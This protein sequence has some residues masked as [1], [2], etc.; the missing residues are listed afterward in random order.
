MHQYPLQLGFHQRLNGLSSRVKLFS[1]FKPC[2]PNWHGPPQK[3]F[4]KILKSYSPRQWQLP[5]QFVAPSNPAANSLQT[6]PQLPILWI[7]CGNRLKLISVYARDFK[8]LLF[9]F[10]LKLIMPNEQ[11]LQSKPKKKQCPLIKS[12]NCQQYHLK[13]ESECA[14]MQFYTKVAIKLQKLAAT[15][16]RP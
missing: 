11:Y 16:P 10:P 4:P 12:C 15:M 14:S 9:V 1:L 2:C 7:L 13:R 6:R 8:F 5:R 3:P